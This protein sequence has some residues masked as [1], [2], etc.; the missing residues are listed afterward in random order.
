MPAIQKPNQ[1]TN[2]HDPPAT[3]ILGGEFSGPQAVAEGVHDLEHVVLI[4]QEVLSQRLLRLE[5]P[6][7]KGEWPVFLHVSET[8]GKRKTH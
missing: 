4:R 2:L 3:V 8:D 5:L 7:R 6:R 1:L